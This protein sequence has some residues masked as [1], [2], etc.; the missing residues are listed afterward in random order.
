[1][2]KHM[3]KT[4]ES[5]HGTKVVISHC[6]NFFLL[7]VASACISNLSLTFSFQ[8]QA[9]SPLTRFVVLHLLPVLNVI[10]PDNYLV[11]PPPGYYLPK[12][13]LDTLTPQP[14][15]TTQ[16]Y[17]LALNAPVRTL[18]R[19]PAW[20]MPQPAIQAFPFPPVL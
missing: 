4:R 11:Q 12:E 19:K 5:K 17:W 10:D 9:Q 2:N 6:R 18:C 1:M 8:K 15:W 7:Y 16:L 20:E 13:Q 14:M 3:N